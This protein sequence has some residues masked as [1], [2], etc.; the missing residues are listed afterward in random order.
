MITDHLSFNFAHRT[1]IF[2]LC[3]GEPVVIR[4]VETQREREME[5]LIKEM[6]SRRAAEAADRGVAELKLD[7]RAFKDQAPLAFS[8]EDDIA[9]KP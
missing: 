3:G 9:V 8:L 7:E 4:P 1:I 6:S 2:S 5:Q